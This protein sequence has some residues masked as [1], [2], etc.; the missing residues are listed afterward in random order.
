[1]YVP[2]SL[3][4]PDQLHDDQALL[5]NLGKRPTLEMGEGE[6]DHLA[7]GVGD[8]PRW[9]SERPYMPF[10]AM[11]VRIYHYTERIRYLKP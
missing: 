7:G 9:A 3:V 11:H 10:L 8:V 2:S 5:L 4:A 1:M 6:G